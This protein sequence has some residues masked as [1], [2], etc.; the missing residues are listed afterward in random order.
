MLQAHYPRKGYSFC[1]CEGKSCEC[2]Y[3][4][5]GGSFELPPPAWGWSD[6]D[7]TSSAEVTDGGQ[8]VYFHP[9]YSNG[10]ACV[11]GDTAF[12]RGSQY[13][14]EIKVTKPVYGSSVVSNLLYL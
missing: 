13:F 5:E 9:G 3:D 10:N 11:R 4:V 12:T 14:W 6:T 2:P 1:A 8:T 7:K